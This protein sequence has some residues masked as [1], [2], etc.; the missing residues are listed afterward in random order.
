MRA[1]AGMDSGPISNGTPEIY[2]GI[3]SCAHISSGLP[4]N[5]LDSSSSSKVK[6]GTDPDPV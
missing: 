6:E 2:D 4:P 5:T 1:G 3:P